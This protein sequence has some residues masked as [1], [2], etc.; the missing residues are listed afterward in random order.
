MDY[1]TAKDIR[2]RSLTSMITNKITAGGGVSSSIKSSLS[3]KMKAKSIGIKEKFDPMNIARFITGG[4]KFAPAIVGRLSGRSQKDI[5]YFTGTKRKAPTYSRVQKSPSTTINATSSDVLTDMLS[6]FQRIDERDTKRREIERAFREEKEVENEKRHTEFIT[7]LKNF[8]DTD[9]GGIPTKKEEEQKKDKGL[10]EV[11]GG[12]LSSMFGAFK[13]LISS[14][15]NL[16]KSLLKPILEAMKKIMRVMF[17]GLMGLTKSLFGLLLKSLKWMRTSFLPFLLRLLPVLAR[18]TPILAVLLAIYGG[19]KLLEYIAENMPDFSKLTPQEARNI[20]ELGNKRMI[21]HYGE[22]NLRSRA[23]EDIPDNYGVGSPIDLPTSAEIAD[24]VPEKVPSLSESVRGT[25]SGQRRKLAEEKWFQRFGATHDPATG[26][27]KDLLDFVGPFRTDPKSG[28]LLSEFSMSPED[29]ANVE[30]FTRSPEETVTP[31][32]GPEPITDAMH[33]GDIL[34]KQSK[35]L[36]TER[37]IR[38]LGTTGGEGVP[39]IIQRNS[40][41]PLDNS[42]NSSPA[43]T[44]NRER[45]FSNTIKRNQPSF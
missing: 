39:N 29:R 21:D 7:V 12:I 19:K 28:K 18:L 40:N 1:Q 2:G 20:L 14:I 5:D 45:I 25:A 17:R 23:Y 30:A 15:T 24:R 27:R 33:L 13:N 32:V 37:R 10:F 36:A 26:I 38:F 3:Q 16:L 35:E 22:E 34:D 4:S 42:P 41:V 6:F 11:L 9:S 44:R 43:Q 31:Y 8:L